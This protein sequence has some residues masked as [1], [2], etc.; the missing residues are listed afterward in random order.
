[1][2]NSVALLQQAKA[3]CYRIYFMV[4]RVLANPTPD[5]IDAVVSAS[6][7]TSTLVPKPTYSL[8]GESYQWESYQKSLLEQARALQLLIVMEEGPFEVRSRGI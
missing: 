6:A 3:D 5:A 7:G 8:D 1:M 2:A 4:Q